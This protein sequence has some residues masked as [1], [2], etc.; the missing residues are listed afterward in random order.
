MDIWLRR[1]YERKRIKIP[2]AVDAGKRA[3]GKRLMFDTWDLSP[4]GVSLAAGETMP[5]GTCV[6]V[7]M[8]L[9]SNQRCQMAGV[10][11]RH[12]RGGMVVKFDYD[13][14]TIMDEFSYRDYFLSGREVPYLP[15]PS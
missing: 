9:P 1:K 5:I 12:V 15:A 10:V 8:I 4:N 6:I 13:C 2:I 7:R 11:W 3:A 14:P